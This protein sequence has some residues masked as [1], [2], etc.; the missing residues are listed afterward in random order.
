[1]FTSG[2]TLQSEAHQEAARLRALR[3][4]ETWTPESKAGFFESLSPPGV[5]ETSSPRASRSASRPASFR[6][7]SSVTSDG[8]EFT[9]VNEPGIRIREGRIQ[10]IPS[11]VTGR[12]GADGEVSPRRLLQSVR[13]H[14][15]LCLEIDRAVWDQEFRFASLDRLRMMEHRYATLQGYA[16]QAVRLACQAVRTPDHGLDRKTWWCRFREILHATRWFLVGTPVQ[17]RAFLRDELRSWPYVREVDRAAQRKHKDKP[18][19]KAT[20]A[21]AKRVARSAWSPARKRDEADESRKRMARM[22]AKKKSLAAATSGD[23]PLL[24]PARARADAQPVRPVQ[25]LDPEGH[26]SVLRGGRE[27][28]AGARGVRG[29]PPRP[30]DGADAAALPDQVPRVLGVDRRRRAVLRPRG[31]EAHVVAEP[32]ALRGADSAAGHP[33]ADR[34]AAARDELDQWRDDDILDMLTR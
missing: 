5:F 32:R 19:Y 15:K 30:V 25:G 22:R 8:P 6:S 27:P 17:K 23:G 24:D 16:V 11:D 33:A 4:H 2:K 28:D 12:E 29:E 26:P 20:E 21:R 14:Q 9:Q 31:P 13:R 34:A 3:A 10:S 18:E 1:M 7:R